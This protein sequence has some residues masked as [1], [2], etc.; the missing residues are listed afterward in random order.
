M[1]FSI[2][3]SLNSFI[4]NEEQSIIDKYTEF[5]IKMKNLIDE[6]FSFT[7][8]LNIG[9]KKNIFIIG[10]IKKSFFN[11]NLKNIRPLNEEPA[12]VL[13]NTI[14]K[15]KQYPKKKEKSRKER[16]EIRNTE[17]FFKSSLVNN[18]NLNKFDESYPKSD[19]D[20]NDKNEDEIEAKLAKLNSNYENLTKQDFKL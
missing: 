1:G 20:K 16:K 3:Y 19:S 11:K 12:I 13:E 4:L 17:D 2:L 6:I 14:D 15:K 10:N 7:E 9:I 8:Y 18:K 5:N